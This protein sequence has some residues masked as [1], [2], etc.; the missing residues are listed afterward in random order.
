MRHTLLGTTAL[1]AMLTVLT[2][3]GAAQG[4]GGR[5]GRGGGR[6]AAGGPPP[7]AEAAAT[8]DVTGYWVALVTE[9]WQWRMAVPERSDV[10]SIPFTNDP[11]KRA[12][13]EAWDPALDEANGDQCKGY[14]AAAIMRVPTRL[15]ITWEN[16][17][18]LRVDTDAGMQTRLLRFGEEAETE[19]GESSLQGWSVAEWD[20]AGGGRGGFGGRGG[21]GAGFPGPAGGGRGGARGGPPPGGLGPGPAGGL[22]PGGLPPAGGGVPGG[23]GRGGPDAEPAVAGALKVVTTHLSPG[24]LRKNGVPYGEH[25]TVT[26]YFHR[27][28]EEY[29]NTYLIVTTIVEDPDY[30][31]APFITSSNFRLLPDEP[32][33][34]GWNPTPCSVL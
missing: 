25:A 4:P 10:S 11:E 27:T 21:R 7:T 33:V 32:A 30:L 24:Y 13:L 1:V 2:F 28:E 22:P 17:N 18:V 29:G 6:G 20:Q 16:E 12:E 34:N 14:G 31:T 26:E 15:H 9:D 8:V 3:P 23:R 5:G 19:P